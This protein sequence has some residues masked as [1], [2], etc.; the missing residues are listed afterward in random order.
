VFQRPG[1]HGYILS[2][3]PDDLLPPTLTL[4]FDPA[5]DPDDLCMTYDRRMTYDTSVTLRDLLITHDPGDKAMA[6]I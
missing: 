4:T 5:R 3:D 6:W 2:F 1:Y